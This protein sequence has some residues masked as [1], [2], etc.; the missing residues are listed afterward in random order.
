M[1][2]PE[3]VLAD[4][5][6]LRVAM[7][8]LP[9]V[10]LLPGGLLPLHIF[11]PR[12]RDM[13]RDALAGTRLL[14]MARL[15]PGYG[16]AYF[17]RPAVHD[18]VGV[19]RIIDSFAWP[20]GRYDLLVRGLIRASIAREHTVSCAY[21]VVQAIC[22]DDRSDEPPA[23]LRAA[24]NQLVTLCDRLASTIAQ[25]GSELRALVHSASS[26]GECADAVSA[27]VVTD[28]EERQLLLEDRDPLSRLAWIIER[29]SRILEKVEPG[30]GGDLPN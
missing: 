13:T 14:A 6:L 24:K 3:D 18:V 8:P 29:V 27:V 2:L 19:G 4:S 30:Q 1:S 15:R 17:D 16:P 10:V 20:D 5:D 25:G 7:F 28:A 21:R 11:E 22:L 9:N 23:V 26:P 12:Y